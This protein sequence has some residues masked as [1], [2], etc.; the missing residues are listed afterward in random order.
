MGRCQEIEGSLSH[1]RTWPREKL[2]MG[3]THL[4]TAA[5]RRRVARLCSCPHSIALD[6]RSMVHEFFWTLSTVDANETKGALPGCTTWNR[7]ML[8]PRLAAPPEVH[9]MM[10]AAS[11]LGRQ[12]MVE[13][14]LYATAGIV[15]KKADTTMKH[16]IIRNTLELGYLGLE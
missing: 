10:P 4:K 7:G 1:L 6:G 9:Y 12:Y 11:R 8:A 2:D 3:A 5:R 16:R 14:T 15:A 13:G